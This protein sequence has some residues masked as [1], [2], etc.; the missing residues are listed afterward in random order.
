MPRAISPAAAAQCE[1][2]DEELLAAIRR[3][4]ETA[5]NRLYERYFQRVYNFAYLRLRNHADAEEAVQETFVAV[6]RSIDAYSGRSSL[7]SSTSRRR[8]VC[9]STCTSVNGSISTWTHSET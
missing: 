9:A 7:G 2:T 4:D 6:F 5:F 8:R 3:G 1:R